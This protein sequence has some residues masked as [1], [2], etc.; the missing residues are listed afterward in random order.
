M[1]KIIIFILI[2][3]IFINNTKALTLNTQSLTAK[4]INSDRIFYSKNMDDKRLIASTTKIMTCILAIESNKLE[5]IVKVG[6]EVL[7]AYGSNIYIEKNEHILLL[8]LVYGL[9]LRSGNDAALTIAK[10][11]GKTIPNFVSMM[12]K[13]AKELK[14]DDTIFENPHG[15]DDNTKNYSTSRDLATLYSYAYQNE[16]FR[17]IV[18]T[19]IYKTNSDKKFYYWV[20]RNKL[21]DNYKYANGGKT[22]YTPQAGRILVSSAKKDDLEVV[23]SSFN[24]NNYDYELHKKIYNEIFNNYKNT[25]LLSKNNFNLKNNKY[26][27]I[28]IK[29]DFSY[30]LT[31]EELTKIKKKVFYYDKPNKDVI[32][33]LYIYL[34]Q[35]IIYNTNLYYK[36]EKLSILNKIKSF[37]KNNLA[38][39]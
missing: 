30:P 1:K 7:Q 17:K 23:I 33:K 20:N 32:G 37:F 19:K 10:Y 27:N 18:N 36:K 9:M 35:D 29:K 15:L 8:D 13:K 12:N 11:V 14:M 22:G 4:D 6:D 39:F 3:F 38:Q 16:T 31:E 2:F 24:N 28:Y 21:I 34:D 25:K 5:D 26:K